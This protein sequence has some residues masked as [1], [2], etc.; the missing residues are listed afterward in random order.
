MKL[1][2]IIWQCWKFIKDKFKSCNLLIQYFCLVIFYL[3]KS[4]FWTAG[5][6]ALAFS[7][8]PPQS[9]KVLVDAAC[10][11]SDMMISA[12]L[13]VHTKLARLRSH[14]IALKNEIQFCIF[15]N[16]MTLCI[17]CLLFN[18]SFNEFWRKGNKRFLPCEILQITNLLHWKITK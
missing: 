16:S 8:K 17:H 12:G 9:I 15:N 3:I 6:K 18:S 10:Q 5:V 13:S 1:L 7:I 2:L 14:C 4:H 11:M